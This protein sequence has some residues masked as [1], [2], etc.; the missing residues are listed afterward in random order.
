MADHRIPPA[1]V[2]PL[3]AHWSE[4]SA[5]RTQRQAQ[6]LA[7]DIAFLPVPVRRR[8]DGWTAARQAAFIGWL[9][10]LGSV[11]EAAAMVGMARAGAYKLRARAGAASFAAAWD[12]ALLWAGESLSERSIRRA[13]TGTA[14]PVIRDGRVTGATRVFDDRLLIALLERVEGRTRRRHRRVGF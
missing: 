9:G 3:D 11:D 12:N 2:E 5:A 10:D 13:I 4:P 8:A 7:A 6:E 1:N 14:V